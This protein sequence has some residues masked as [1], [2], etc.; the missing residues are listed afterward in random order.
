MQ[1]IKN[2]W[3]YLKN[4]FGGINSFIIFKSVKHNNIKLYFN[5]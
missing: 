4:V 5:D 1:R 3:I 2:V